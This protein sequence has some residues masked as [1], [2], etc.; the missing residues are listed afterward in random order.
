MKIKNVLTLQY[1]TYTV[2]KKKL[3]IRLRKSYNRKRKSRIEKEFDKNETNK[4]K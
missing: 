2:N 4:I 1:F 3:L